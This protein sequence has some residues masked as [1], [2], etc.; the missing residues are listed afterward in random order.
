MDKLAAHLIEKETITGKE[1]MKIYRAEKGLPEPEEGEEGKTADN[2]GRIGEKTD[3]NQSGGNSSAEAVNDEKREDDSQTAGEMPENEN[4]AE[5]NFFSKAITIEQEKIRDSFWDS[6]K[7][8]EGLFAGSQEGN[9]GSSGRF[10][11]EGNGQETEDESGRNDN[12]SDQNQ[13]D[14]PVGR[15]SNTTGNFGG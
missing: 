14:E 1:F 6:D 8:S 12:N 10:A 9:G 7:G 4:K 13:G 15:F 2:A 11:D 5:D 3:G